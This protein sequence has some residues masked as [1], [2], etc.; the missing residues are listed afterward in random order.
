MINYAHR[1]ASEQAPENT[2]AAFHRALVLGANG[3]ETDIQQ[4]KD[5][6][7]VLF[8]DASLVR[9]T[10]TDLPIQALTLAQLA[11][12][13]FG[14]HKGPAF[15]QEPIPTLPAFLAAFG[16]KPIHLAL[17]LKETGIEQAVLEALTGQV[18]W[19]QVVVTSFLWDS[20]VA[21]RALDGNI[22]LGYLTERITEEG[23]DRLAQ[24]GLNQICPKADQLTEQ[25]VELAK[26]GGF[27]V[28]AWGVNDDRL[29]A[30]ALACGVDGMTVDFPDR[31]AALLTKNH[32]LS[33]G[34]VTP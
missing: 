31:L 8:H 21:M 24:A 18:F 23:L 16:T 27:S 10:G 34:S 1:G 11:H 14:S 22:R 26:A 7:L 15:A 2:F 6:Q 32:V 25:A 17:E 28:R 3:I 9:I 33:A 19:D 4:T 12:L 29:M 13:D 5:Q 30:H 20:L